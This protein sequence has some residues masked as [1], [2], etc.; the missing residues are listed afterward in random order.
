[1]SR[2]KAEVGE[3]EKIA[4]EILNSAY[5]ESG[6]THQQIADEIGV[7]RTTVLKSLAGQRATTYTELEGIAHA[8]GLEAWKVYREAEKRAAEQQNS[9][10]ANSPE[11]IP[12]HATQA[13]ID[14][15]QRLAREAIA[16]GY[17]LAAKHHEPNPYDRIGEESQAPTED[18]G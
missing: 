1:M 11:T 10:N 4:L 5:L 17:A 3:S 18:E 12:E 13:Y 7:S 8:L 9:E 15:A 14:E 6:K 2:G 16:N